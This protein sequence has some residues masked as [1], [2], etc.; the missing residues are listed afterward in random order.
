[1]HSASKRTAAA[2][3]SVPSSGGAW[4]ATRKSGPS[5]RVCMSVRVRAGRAGGGGGGGGVEGVAARR[6]ARLRIVGRRVRFGFGF[7]FGFA[8]GFVLVVRLMRNWAQ[9]K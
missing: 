8:L 7:E 9:W 3:V 4:V 5:R 1:M 2:C 6:E